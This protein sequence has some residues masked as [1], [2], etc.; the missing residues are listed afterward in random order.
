MAPRLPRLT[1]RLARDNSWISL[2]LAVAA[3]TIVALGVIVIMPGYTNSM[4]RLYSSKFGYGSL[5]RRMKKPFA[6]TST[7]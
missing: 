5:L 4:S 6:V 7:E 2:V 1:I 3:T